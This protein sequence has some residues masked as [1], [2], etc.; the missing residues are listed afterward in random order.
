MCQEPVAI[1]NWLTPQK[2]QKTHITQF[3]NIHTPSDHCKG[4]IAIN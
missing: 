4:L 2:M 3:L 1:E